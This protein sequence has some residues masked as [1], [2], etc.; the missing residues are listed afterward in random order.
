MVTIRTNSKINKKQPND[1]TQAYVHLS[2]NLLIYHSN[3]VK[4]QSLSS[5]IAR[6]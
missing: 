5:V 2:Q 6:I 4:P 3:T 1:V